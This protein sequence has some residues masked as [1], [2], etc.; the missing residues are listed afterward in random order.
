MFFNSKKV[1]ELQNKVED[2][3]GTLKVAENINKKLND[4]IDELEAEKDKL[5]SILKE[6]KKKNKKLGNAENRNRLLKDQL[7]DEILLKDKYG[8][9][10]VDEDSVVP[11]H[12]VKSKADINK[13]YEIIRLMC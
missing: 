2:L 8:N 10:I 1:K 3:E 11:K 12:K 4:Y 9:L 13:M 7:L 6:S 5:K